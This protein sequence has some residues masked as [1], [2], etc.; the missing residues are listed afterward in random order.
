FSARSAF[1]TSST[2]G[3]GSWLAHSTLQSGLWISNQQ[4]YADL[5]KRNRLT[6][7][8]AFGRAGWR[9]VGAV[10]GNTQDWPDAAFYAYHHI[11][12]TRNIGYSGRPFAFASIPDQYT[13]SAFQRAELAAPNHPPVFAE[14]D[15]LSSHAPWEPVPGMLDWSAVGDG[16]IYGVSTGPTD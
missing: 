6:L 5:V 9:T 13:M 10:P 4:L 14:I 12:D 7:T 2:N 15:L 16:S 8:S 3:G 1:L 11:D